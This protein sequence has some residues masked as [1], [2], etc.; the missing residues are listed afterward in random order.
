MEVI[1]EVKIKR[2][3]GSIIFD[4]NKI[5]QSESDV[6]VLNDELIQI[7]SLNLRFKWIERGE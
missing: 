7:E 1:V 3:D 2:K 6:D 5:L 4:E